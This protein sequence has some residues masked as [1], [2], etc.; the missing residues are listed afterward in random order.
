MFG[1]LRIVTGASANHGNSLLQL[2]GTVRRWERFASVAVYDLGLRDQQVRAIAE[3]GF[4]ATRFP[5]EDFPPHLDIS[6]NRGQYAWKPAIIHLELRRASSPLLWLDAGD[7]L[8]FPVLRIR[9][10]LK[11]VGFHSPRSG[12]SIGKWTH[13]GMLE[14]LGLPAG[15]GAELAPLNGAVVGFN[16][17]V[18]A[19][20]KLADEWFAGAMDENVIAPPGSDRT[21]HRQDQALLSILAYRSGLID[22]PSRPDL[23]VLTH[24]DLPEE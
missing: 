16:P 12:G 7:V 11:T 18:P 3:L 14:A 15:W 13:P 19:A 23:A 10:H 6:V 17:E 5:Y 9:H 21:N 2:L 22:R 24:R 8:R 4:V 20:R 1:K